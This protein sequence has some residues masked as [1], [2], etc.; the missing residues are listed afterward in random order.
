MNYK[1]VTN[2]IPSKANPLNQ[3]LEVCSA[4]NQNDQALT[5]LIQSNSSYF[6]S[7]RNHTNLID[8]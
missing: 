6:K 4:I 2:L 3:T 5:S 8:I 7:I 1:F